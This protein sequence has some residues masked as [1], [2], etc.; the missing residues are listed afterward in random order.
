MPLGPGPFISEPALSVTGSRALAARAV[1]EDFMNR[2]RSFFA[3][4]TPTIAMLVVGPAHAAC[5]NQNF[6]LAPVSYNTGQSPFHS[7]G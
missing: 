4:V 6:F 3:C 2:F 7:I 5:P 1:L